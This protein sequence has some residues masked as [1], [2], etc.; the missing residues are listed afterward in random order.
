MKQKLLILACILLSMT[1]LSQIRSFGPKLGVGI[2]KFYGADEYK[3]LDPK[4]GFVAGGFLEYGLTQRI[5]LQSEIL[6]SMQGA[7]VNNNY[8]IGDIEFEGDNTYYNLNYLNI[9]V[10][11]GYR[12]NYEFTVYAGPQFGYLLSAEKEVN[13]YTQDIM[14]D[15]HQFEL[16]GVLGVNYDINNGFIGDIR[17][18]Y[19]FTNVL[20]KHIDDEEM[21]VVNGVFQ[22]MIGYKIGDNRY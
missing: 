15:Y 3:K 6:Y 12:L 1:A 14:N 7:M 11:A 20:E 17:F 21:N 9:P 8:A 13:G 22:L 4:G 19:G 2:S 18:N 16:S 5:S 10:L